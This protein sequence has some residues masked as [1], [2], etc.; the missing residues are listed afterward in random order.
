MITKV[1]FQWFF[2]VKCKIEPDFEDLLLEEQD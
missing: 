2:F 1:T